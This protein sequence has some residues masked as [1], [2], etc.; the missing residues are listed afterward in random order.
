MFKVAFPLGLSLQIASQ[1][2]A[3]PPRAWVPSKW[4]FTNSF[5]RIKLEQTWV[6]LDPR[7]MRL[8]CR[9]KGFR[10][11]P[12][13]AR[14]ENSCWIEVGWPDPSPS[15]LG[16]MQQLAFKSRTISCVLVTPSQP[17]KTSGKLQTTVIQSRIIVTLLRSHKVLGEQ[18]CQD[19]PGFIS[20]WWC[21]A[22]S[23]W[24]GCVLLA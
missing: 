22:H 17:N 12:H 3:L 24:L 10:A 1:L 18:G 9:L 7:G 19:M 20:Q 4:P 16:T 8:F 11:V 23:L 15:L 21:L 2:C 6:L 13:V 5:V 14:C